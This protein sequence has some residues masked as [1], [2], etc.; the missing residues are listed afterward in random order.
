MAI[1]SIILSSLDGNN[2]FRVDGAAESDRSGSSVSN[3]GD[4]NGESG[5]A[6]GYE[7]HG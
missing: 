2:G 6:G 5:V 7:C 3:S 1:T 4:V